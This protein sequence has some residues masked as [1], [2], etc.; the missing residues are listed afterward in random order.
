MIRSELMDGLSEKRIDSLIYDTQSYHGGIPQIMQQA[1]LNE[2]SQ[3]DTAFMQMAALSHWQQH[4]DALLAAPYAPIERIRAQQLTQLRTLV[5]YAF[6]NVEFY[7]N[8]YGASGYTSGA[9]Q[10]WNDFAFLPIVSK[11][12][13]IEQKF[14]ATLVDGAD[15][16]T[17]FN[18]RSSG[19]SG[20]PM[21]TWLDQSD[22]I[23]DFAE[24]TRFLHE[25]TRGVLTPQDWIY[26]LHH[27]GF[28][29]S[30]V[31][32][33]Y[34][35]FRLMDLEQV[36]GLVAHW[37][38]LRPRVLTTLPSYLP[39]LASIG[40][41]RRYGIEAITTNSEM[42]SREE[43]SRYS[44]LFDVPVLDEYSSEEI[45]FMATECLDGRHHV[46]E[47]GVYMEIADADSEGVGRV[48]VTDLGNYLMP[49]IRYDHGDL[50]RLSN[51]SCRCGRSFRGLDALHGRRDDALIAADGRYVPTAS[52]MAA[53]DALL[54]DER[55]G[56][57]EY[58]LI[59]CS[60]N[61]IELHYVR[62][63]GSGT[64]SSSALAALEDRLS[65]LIGHRV[66]LQ[67]QRYDALPALPSYKRRILLRTWDGCR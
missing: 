63:P 34:R 51:G 45:G 15:R 38:K 33:K 36:D 12:E 26:T 6:A 2:Y 49:L 40:S 60:A 35:V 64:D 28:W 11:K 41:L 37:R 19:S 3:A 55:S 17:G 22:V 48:V 31:L 66:E 54:T 9:L 67:A 42:S 65:H 57:N 56:M 20:V 50:A 13:I 44:Q 53:C 25:A 29:Y 16:I 61:Q 43:R 4:R 46:V 1:V 27:G 23:R 52:V 32:G 24:Q 39:M 30:S 10:S 18:T 58:R 59:Q 8:L 5:D 7:R 47:D 62:S 21:T 14:G